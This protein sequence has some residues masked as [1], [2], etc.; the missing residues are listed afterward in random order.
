M[1]STTFIFLLPFSAVSRTFDPFLPCHSHHIHPV[2]SRA[3]SSRNTST[4]NNTNN[5]NSSSNQSSQSSQ[6]QQ[7]SSQTTTPEQD[8]PSSRENNAESAPDDPH[9]PGSDGSFNIS[10]MPRN[11]TNLFSNLFPGFNI[12]N[13]MLRRDSNDANNSQNECEKIINYSNIL[14][15]E[16]ADY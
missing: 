7:N 5:Q 14:I 9:A 6:T 8:Q 4:A 10:D 15:V 11:F 3:T 1:F 12:G 16:V 13:V 2:L